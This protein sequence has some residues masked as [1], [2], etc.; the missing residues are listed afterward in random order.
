MLN[1]VI[2]DVPSPPP[3]RKR[4]KKIK[5]KP[6]S[7]SSETLAN[8]AKL[9]ENMLKMIEEE[10]SIEIDSHSDDNTPRQSKLRIRCVFDL[11]LATLSEGFELIC[12]KMF[13]FLD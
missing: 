5:R 7:S 12:K 3:L 4:M 6:K 13:F 9:L 1:N 10:V 2:V 8:N 11:I